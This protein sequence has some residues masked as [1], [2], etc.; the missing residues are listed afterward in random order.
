MI[1]IFKNRVRKEGYKSIQEMVKSICAVLAEKDTDTL[2][3][4]WQRFFKRYNQLL[5]GRDGNDFEIE[6]ME[7]A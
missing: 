4:V 7:I 1:R 3:R 2:D 6:D 5:R